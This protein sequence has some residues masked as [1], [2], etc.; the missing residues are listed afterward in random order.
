MKI[1]SRAL[2][3][4]LLCV[5]LCLVFVSGCSFLPPLKTNS[6]AP[7]L[8]TVTETGGVC[9]EGQT[10]CGGA[11]RN[12]LVDSS[13]CGRCG[14]VCS[15]S[16]YC[17]NG[18]CS[19]GTLHVPVTGITTAAPA[20]GLTTVTT[21]SSSTCSVGQT[22]CSGVCRNLQADAG[23]CGRCGNICGSGRTCS[24]GACSGSSTAGV[25]TTLV[26]TVPAP[27]PDSAAA[28]TTTTTPWPACPSGTI[29]CGGSCIDQNTDNS[30]C[31]SCGNGCLYEKNCVSGVC[32][33]P[34]GLTVCEW[35]CFNTNTDTN[36]CGGCGNVCNADQNCISGVCVCP[37]GHGLCGPV[38]V[39]P[40]TDNANC[41]YCGVSCPAGQHCSVGTCVLDSTPACA[42]GQTLCSGGK[43]GSVCTD[44]NT[45]IYNCGSCGYACTTGSCSGGTC[46]YV[47][48]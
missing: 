21:L 45:D 17:N 1:P 24:S 15:A 37:E 26:T 43:S 18:V 4:I 36:N 33:C 3:G 2:P 30:N 7:P 5:L 28:V 6:S 38:C 23:N 8:L 20:G 22:P 44:L 39:N 9:A 41:G 32:S 27:L 40:N 29:R 34:A 31:G 47:L 16:Q 11:C 14:N 13:N 46:G 12:T 19:A 10:T 42:K 25:F 48:K 35:H